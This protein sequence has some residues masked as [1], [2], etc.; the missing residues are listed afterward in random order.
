ML[1]NKTMKNCNKC[2]KFK[3]YTE[4]FKDK[5]FKDGHSS[6]CKLCKKEYKLKNKDKIKQ[7]H[8]NNY[9]NNKDKIDEYNKNWRIENRQEFNLCR[10]KW[11]AKNPDKVN[12]RKREQYHKWKKDPFYNMKIRLRNRLNAALSSKSWRKNTKFNVMIGCDQNTL[13]QYIESKFSQGMNWNN[14]N[15]WH[16]DHIIPV[17]AANNIKELEKLFHYTNLQPLWAEE[18]IKKSDLCPHP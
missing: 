3:A 18:N 9:I 1:Y 2:L 14:R 10:K 6:I 7:W 17:S 12:K 13:L 4:F 5:Y 15:L 11:R 16:L 8:K